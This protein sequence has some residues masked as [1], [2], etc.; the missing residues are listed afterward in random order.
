MYIKLYVVLI[1]FQHKIHTKDII[2]I[3]TVIN[4]IKLNYYNYYGN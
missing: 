2:Y 3:V 1:Y 4:L